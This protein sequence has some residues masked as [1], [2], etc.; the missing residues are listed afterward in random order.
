V[1]IWATVGTTVV[2]GGSVVGGSVVGGSEVVE[3]DG[4]VLV[5]ADG[6]VGRATFTVVEALVES[7]P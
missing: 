7:E 2:V 3:S 5:T 4:A 6:V 1:I